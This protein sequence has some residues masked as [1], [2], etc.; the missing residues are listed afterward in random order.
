MPTT[1][2]RITGH[3]ISKFEKTYE[4]DSCSK[5]QAV[6]IFLPGI[7]EINLMHSQLE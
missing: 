3:L 2:C 5:N 7:A 6:L 1:H 4:R